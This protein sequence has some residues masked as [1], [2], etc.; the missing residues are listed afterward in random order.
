M[1]ALF[2]VLLDAL[3]LAHAGTGCAFSATSTN[4]LSTFIVVMNSSAN[5]C[6]SWSC[7]VPAR[8]EKARLQRRGLPLHIVIEAFQFLGETPHFLRIHDRL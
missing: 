4:F 1:L 3:G 2:Q 8:A 6:C 5:F 7:Q